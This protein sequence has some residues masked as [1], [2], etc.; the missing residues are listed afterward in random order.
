[1]EWMAYALG[2]GFW[3]LFALLVVCAMLYIYM[4]WLGYKED[5]D[6]I[7]ERVCDAVLAKLDEIKAQENPED[8][9]K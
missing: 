5:Q 6:G 2:V 8:D 7:V 1:M 4:C 3:T 9:E